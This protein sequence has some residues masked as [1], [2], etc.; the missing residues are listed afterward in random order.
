MTDH[1]TRVLRED[2]LRAANTLFRAALHVKASSDE[3]WERTRGGY[4]PGRA[5]GVFDDELIGTAR[6]TDSELTV[7]GGGQVPLA[8]VTGVGVRADRTRRGVLTELMR[9]QFAD[10][11]DRGVV[12]ANLFASEGAIYG[13]FGYGVAT[14]SRSYTVTPRLA[15]LRPEVF[16]GGEVELIGLEPGLDQL[17]EHYARM[18]KR[19]GMMARASYWWTVL[20]MT[21]RRGEEP[22]TI[23]VHHGPHE[24][25][26]FAIYRV[27]RTPGGGPSVLQIED[28]HA[29]NADAFAGLW[30][31]LLGVDLIDEIQADSRPLDEPIELL[32]TDPR[33]CR[34]T[35]SG[36]ETW[37]RLLDVPAALA[38]RGHAED[39]D[40]LV[41]E[42]A[43]PVLGHNSGRYLVTPDEVRR[44]DEQAALRLGVDALAMVYLGGWRPSVLAQAG[45]VQVAGE[46]TAYAADR[47]FGA[48]TTPWCG[49]FF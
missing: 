49:T 40:P 8:A 26:G 2:E 46:R 36:D 48:R 25:D 28:M 20:S 3:E 45:R 13:R 9:T 17:P 39:G 11:A 18:T 34:V 47:L 1:Q 14:L 44:T 21:L 38:A 31:F 37:L 7:P 32:F 35:E 23:A 42:V 33:A 41:V 29:G 10:F 27:K 12:A 15:R 4:Q 24:V 22:V 5:L 30:R 6:S 43:D 19:P 16:A